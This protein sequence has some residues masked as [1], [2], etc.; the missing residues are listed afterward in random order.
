MPSGAVATSS[1]KA[2]D[3]AGAALPDASVSS[4]SRVDHNAPG[5]S[6][7]ESASEA[8]NDISSELEVRSQAWISANPR[9]EA[10]FAGAKL[11]PAACPVFPFLYSAALTDDS[12]GLRFSRAIQSSDT[13]EEV[14]GALD[15]MFLDHIAVPGLEA[16]EGWHL[17][18]RPSTKSRSFTDGEDGQR[19]RITS[20]DGELLKWTVDGKGF[21][22]I[23]GKRG[24]RFEAPGPEAASA[25]V[26]AGG[27]GSCF[28]ARGTFHG[29]LHFECRIVLGNRAGAVL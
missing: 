22:S 23:T 8:K 1:P 11:K 18:A 4:P 25:G 29:L 6:A 27:Q 19:I 15:F 20:F 13:A 17:V 3:G 10:T 2:E 7:A 16:A 5:E 12:Y 26:P 21:S 28:E 9:F 24:S 14:Q